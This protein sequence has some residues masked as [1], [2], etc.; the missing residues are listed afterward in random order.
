[1]DMK[2][3]KYI[4]YILLIFIVGVFFNC[5]NPFTVNSTPPAK[6]VLKFVGAPYFP[7]YGGNKVRIAVSLSHEVDYTGIYF[8][9]VNQ[10]NFS[11][12]VLNINDYYDSQDYIDYGDVFSEVKNDQKIYTIQNDYINNNDGQTYAMPGLTGISFDGSPSLDEMRILI[13]LSND[14]AL[15][16]S[17][18]VKVGAVDNFANWAIVQTNILWGRIS[19]TLQNSGYYIN[20]TKAIRVAAGQYFC[21]VHP[22]QYFPNLSGDY[23]VTDI[24]FYFKNTIDGY[25]N[26]NYS[27]SST[28]YNNTLL[29]DT[30]VTVLQGGGG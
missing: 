29:F 13:T 11:D 10:G 18:K 23:T 27:S 17:T 15:L 6:P 22:K 28:Y 8:G 1:M 25:D 21:V 16:V 19:L 26:L 24:S 5:E 7:E 3:N 9:F 14:A 2:T 12:I 20:T 4:L 30:G